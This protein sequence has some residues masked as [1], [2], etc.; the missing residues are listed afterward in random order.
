MHERNRRIAEPAGENHALECSFCRYPRSRLTIGAW[1][2]TATHVHC[3]SLESAKW[4]L[5]K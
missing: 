2:H 4:F 5:K 3:S 1:L